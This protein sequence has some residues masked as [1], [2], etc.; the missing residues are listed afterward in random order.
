MFVLCI[1]LLIFDVMLVFIRENEVNFVMPFNLIIAIAC[2]T[3]SLNPNVPPAVV[4]SI[5]ILRAHH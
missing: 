1:L 3:F 2:C 4:L 5:I